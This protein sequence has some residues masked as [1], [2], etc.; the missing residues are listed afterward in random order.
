MIFAMMSPLVLPTLRRV[1]LTSLWSNPHWMQGVF[2][3]C[4]VGA[5]TLLTLA[6]PASTGAA[7]ANF[8]R[9]VVDDPRCRTS[10]S[11]RL[12]EVHV[13]MTSVELCVG[14]AARHRRP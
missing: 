5:W 8:S 6:L 3:V 13:R 12:A 9:D 4:Y 1:A 14:Q 11:W 7:A 2:L 10:S